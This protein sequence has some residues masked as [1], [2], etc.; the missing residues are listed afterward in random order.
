MNNIVYQI[1]FPETE[2]SSSAVDKS[3]FTLGPGWAVL[4]GLK[5]LLWNKENSIFKKNHKGISFQINMLEYRF[6]CVH[7]MTPW[8]M[9]GASFTFFN[10]S[11]ASLLLWL[12]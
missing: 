1:V 2:T 6:S 12:F 9:V 5:F 3:L 7:K 10:L 8:V 11:P 4:T